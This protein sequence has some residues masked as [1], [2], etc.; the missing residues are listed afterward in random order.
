MF[1][2]NKYLEYTDGVVRFIG[3]EMR[4]YIPTIYKKHNLLTVTDT[5]DALGIFEVDIEEEL[6]HGL[7]LPAVLS[8]RPSDTAFATIGGTDY[9]RCLFTRG[10]VFL[11]STNV[12][13]TSQLAYI[14]FTEYIQFSRIPK[15]IDYQKC[16]FLFDIIKQV[17]DSKINVNHAVFEM[18]FSHLARDPENIKQPYRHSDM[19]KPP[20]FV[21]LDDAANATM[22]VT[23]KLAGGYFQ[24]AINGA[25]ASPNEDV[26]SE[27]EDLLRQ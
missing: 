13:K 14:L 17:T 11:T 9:C 3:T 22:T 10:D 12:V 8:M 16:A 7:F 18:I 1:D 6:S 2:F 5:V 21:K 19:T 15:F 4:I 25:L 23:S 27:I 26:S 24:D 20:R